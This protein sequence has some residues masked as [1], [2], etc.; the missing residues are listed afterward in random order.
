MCPHRTHPKKPAIVA[1]AASAK[2]EIAVCSSRVCSR[3]LLDAIS[4]VMLESTS[5]RSEDNL[6]EDS[7]V[8]SRRRSSIKEI[9]EDTEFS[10]GSLRLQR[11]RLTILEEKLSR[12]VFI[13]RSSDLF[14]FVGQV[15]SCKILVYIPLNR[16]QS[17]IGHNA[18]P[19]YQYQ[20]YLRKEV[21]I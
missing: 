12:L 6:K 19:R 11:E 17:A 20:P 3:I 8:S 14:E 10:G 2:V 5:L 4:K 13:S 1:P 7:F 18:D 9:R 15:H 21:L 16:K